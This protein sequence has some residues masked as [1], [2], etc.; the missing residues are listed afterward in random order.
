MVTWNRTT[1][2]GDVINLNYVRYLIHIDSVEYMLLYILLVYTTDVPRPL[3]NDLW[4]F[5]FQKID[6]ECVR[7]AIRS[8]TSVYINAFIVNLNTCLKPLFLRQHINIVNTV[9]LLVYL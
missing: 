9:T 5:L 1:D 7:L 3:I 8:G 6:A 2:L 4:V